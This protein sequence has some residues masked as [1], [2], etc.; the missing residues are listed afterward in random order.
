MTKEAKTELKEAETKLE[1][2]ETKLE[3]AKTELK[4]AETKL[5]NA[6]TEL[7]EAEGTVKEANAQKLYD[8]AVAGV[9]SAQAGVTSAQTVVDA[10]SM[11]YA[12][13]VTAADVLS[14]ASSSASS[15]G[16]S[17]AHLRLFGKRWC[18]WLAVAVYLHRVLISS[19][20]AHEH[21]FWFAGSFCA[22]GRM[23]LVTYFWYF[24][25]RLSL[26]LDIAEGS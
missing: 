12:Q 24:Q 8:V 11:A 4:E 10:L 23:S 14:L 22:L 9:T 3:K 1:K 13:T 7:K 2:A 21:R 26:R 18:I 15:L 25:P 16:E 17:I 6:K 5:E 19:Y 20:C